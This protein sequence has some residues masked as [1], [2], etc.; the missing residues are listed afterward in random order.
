MNLNGGTGVDKVSLI[1]LGA[2]THS[3]DQNQR[4]VNLVFSI[5]PSL[6]QATQTLQVTPP[7]N[8]N[9]APPGDYMLFVLTRVN[10][11]LVP[12]QA[13]AIIRISDGL[14]HGYPESVSAWQGSFTGDETNL[15]QSDNSYVVIDPAGLGMPD[16]PRAGVEVTTTAPTGSFSALTFRLEAHTT[17]ARTQRIFLWN[18]LTS[19]WEQIGGDQNSSLQD[20]VFDVAVSG[21]PSRFIKAGSNA[22]KARIGWFDS[23][24]SG[25]ANPEARV[26]EVHWALKP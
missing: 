22:M 23:V 7:A 24:S 26:D 17:D 14:V 13:A 19:L 2:V 12:C 5:L 3:F 18:H 15:L 11:V 8:A 1:R 21:D 6:T 4:F 25:P 9:D 20:K 10:N 16:Q